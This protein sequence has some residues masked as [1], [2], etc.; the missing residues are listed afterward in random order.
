MSSQTRWNLLDEA[1][2][3]VQRRD[4]RQ[5]G[6][7]LPGVLRALGD[8]DVQAFLALRRHQRHAWHMFLAQLAALALQRVGLTVEAWRDVDWKRALGLLS[9][10]DETAW[11]LDVD[12]VTRP[13]FM[14]PPVPE[15]NLSS[16]KL[17]GRAP[18]VIDVLVTSKNHD[19]K[20]ERAVDARADDWL[21]ALVSL[22]TMEG[23]MGA[24]KYGI[25]RMNGGYGS[26]SCIAMSTGLGL[27]ARIRRDAG[28]LLDTEAHVRRQLG[29]ADKGGLALLW[30]VPWDGNDSLPLDQLHPFFIEVCRRIRMRRDGDREVVL[31]KATKSG[32]VLSKTV[33]AQ[34]KGSL[35][36][37]WTPIHVDDAKALSP[38]G[39]GFDYATVS[40][41]LFSGDFRTGQA[42]RHGASDRFFSAAVL[43]RGQGGTA[44]FHE[45]VVFLP[46]AVRGLLRS[47]GGAARAFGHVRGHVDAASIARQALRF[48]VTTFLRVAAEGRP[49]DATKTA[50]AKW[51]RTL[52]EDMDA[53][54]FPALWL[55]LEKDNDGPLL[56]WHAQLVGLA[57]RRFAEATRSLPSP[58]ARRARAVAAGE[59]ALRGTLRK[60]GLIKPLEAAVKG[61]GR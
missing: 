29:Y 48:A 38:S 57:H 13:A 39:R 2:I 44:G 54:F 6:L 11:T 45:R 61:E 34:T 43:A 32:R 23:V 1:L 50:A 28:I 55:S 49:N 10:G 8:D 47:D 31:D 40:K 20:Q 27:A 4:K 9:D 46:K 24:G 16:F 35:G 59:S 37:V 3:R 52:D 25:A 56:D 33:R 17:Q 60:H 7:S 30:M 42:Q 22:Q 41:L 51:A 12:D 58:V 36:D 15:G 18:D 5:E 53:R 26:R 19:V 14:Q 21:F